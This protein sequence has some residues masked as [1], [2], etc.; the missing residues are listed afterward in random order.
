MDYTDKVQAIIDRHE[1]IKLKWMR[2]N[3][4]DLMDWIN[5]WDNIIDL[6]VEKESWYNIE[7]QE[8]K[9]EKGKKKIELKDKKED[10]KKVHTE[11]TADAILDE[12]FYER[13]KLQ[14]VLRLEIKL[15]NEKK[16]IIN[17]YI[18]MWKKVLFK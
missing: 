11:S 5:I 9:V 18:Q 13:D 10:G 16:I 17:E 1:A 6:M 3:E 7:R 14:D 2:L 12:L 15:L 4:Q 8:L